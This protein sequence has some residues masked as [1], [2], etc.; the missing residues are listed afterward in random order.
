MRLLSLSGTL[1]GGYSSTLF[2]LL[3][4]FSPEIRTDFGRSEE[5]RWIER[6]GFV[7][8]TVGCDDGDSLEDGR[9]SR[10]RK[11]RRVVRERPELAPVALFHLIGNSA[12]LRLSDVFSGLLP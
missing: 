3:Y 2:H 9:A 4:R 12:F 8:H 10:R 5:C 7:E 11:Y 1:M 6:Y